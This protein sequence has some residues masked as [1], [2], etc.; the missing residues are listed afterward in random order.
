MK[1]SIDTALAY[2]AEKVFAQPELLPHVAGKLGKLVRGP[3]VAGAFVMAALLSGPAA[4]QQ[5]GSV[6]NA[7]CMLGGA[8]G[9]LL[10]HNVGGGKGK[11]LA[12][13]AGAVGG[14]AMGNAIQANAQTR[15]QPIPGTVGVP[16]NFG[17]P[18]P[19]LA[20]HPMGN[21]SGVM[22]AQLN[23]DIHPTHAMAQEDQLRMNK[24]L[25]AAE[26]KAQQL[27][28]A[29]QAEAQVARQLQDARGMQASTRAQIDVNGLAP[30]AQNTYQI[31]GQYNQASRAREEAN[32]NYGVAGMMVL[33]FGAE[34]A[35]EGSDL[36]SFKSRILK[37]VSEP[38][39]SPVEMTD[40]SSRQRVTFDSG[41]TAPQPI[42]NGASRF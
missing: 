36:S 23:G 26:A 32:K 12:T 29:R 28:I 22:F 3:V 4:A 1:G 31:Q 27:Q 9:G 11:T 18:M 42:A 15:P 37:V 16:S 8:A 33:K 10:G 20:T 25:L 17:G 30:L 13:V 6:L 21:Y 19:G 38:M 2:A 34:L 7:G 41:V 5:M 35:G 14:C 40:P 24:V 39:T